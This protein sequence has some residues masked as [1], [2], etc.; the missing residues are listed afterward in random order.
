[1][2]W[3]D[4]I[5]N[6]TD[7][8]LSKLQETVKDRET[9]HAAVHGVTKSWT[10]MS[11]G[12]PPPHPGRTAEISRRRE[13]SQLSTERQENLDT[14]K[15]WVIPPNSR[16]KNWMVGNEDSWCGL[17]SP[18]GNDSVS[19]WCYLHCLQVLTVE[20]EWFVPIADSSCLEGSS[21]GTALL[22]SVMPSS[23]WRVWEETLHVCRPAPSLSSGSACWKLMLSHLSGG[24]FCQQNRATGQSLTSVGF[25]RSARQGW[26]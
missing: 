15:R 26:V 4:G 24:P 25:C 8:S 11:D 17:C 9:W 13:R 7:M 10:W 5:T 16:G 6:S 14:W 18:F 12:T 23:D 1:M 20:G 19:W 2:R 21:R 3:L 22:A